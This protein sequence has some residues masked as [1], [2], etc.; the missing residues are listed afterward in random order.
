M[1]TSAVSGALWCLPAA[2]HVAHQLA[3]T[4][5]AGLGGRSRL[6]Q[7]ALRCAGV[8]TRAC[9]STVAVHHVAHSHQQMLHQMYR[10]YLHTAHTLLSCSCLRSVASS[11]AQ[12]TSSS[13]A[14]PA[15]QAAAAAPQ[16]IHVTVNGRAAEL[17]AGSSLYDAVSKVGAF[18]PVLCKHPRLPN[19]P[20]SCRCVW[21][22]GIESSTAQQG[23]VGGSAGHACLHT[24]R[25]AGVRVL[26][27]KAQSSC[28]VHAVVIYAGLCRSCL[29][30]KHTAACHLVR[31]AH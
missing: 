27:T 4:T 31:V 5:L 13:T 19:T 30:C 12:H 7:G 20:G 22:H 18:V 11:S 10:D 21:L 8:C 1:Q 26:R 15:A 2:S 24:M 28:A 17:P 29:R 6:L 25:G 14:V 3:G 9:T 16:T 23:R